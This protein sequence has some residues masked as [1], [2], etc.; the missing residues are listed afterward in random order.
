MSKQPFFFDGETA[1][2][3]TVAL[4]LRDEALVIVDGETDHVWSWDDVREMR[5]QADE[6]EMVFSHADAGEAR[7]IVYDP[8]VIDAIQMRTPERHKVVVPAGTARRVITW[9][10]LAVGSVMLIVF[11]II[12]SLANVLT[13]L[14]PVQREVALGRASMTQIET[15]LLNNERAGFCVAEEGVAAIDA[16]EARLSDDFES[17]YDYRI[18]VYNSPMVNAFAVPGGNIVFFNGLIQSA[19]SPEQV[20][21]VLAHEIAHVENRDSLRLMLRAAGSAGILSMLIGDF[22]GGAVVLIVAEQLVSASHSQK[23]ETAADTFAT[24]R[25]AAVGL[26][27]SPFAKFFDQMHEEHGPQSEFG[28]VLEEYLG[29]HPELLGRAAAARSANTI[30][31]DFV[32]VLTEEEWAGL[33]SIC[34]ETEAVDADDETAEETEN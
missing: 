13:N 15:L 1:G 28:Q 26:P 23:A 24:D 19:D 5:D 3:R 20:A 22:A 11:V 6:M 32:P 31:G 14:V 10:G 17:D 34:S 4:D 30:E 8:L 33:R 25:L 18:R 16:M 2:G 21:G 7:L 9:G 12:P 29:T 27:S